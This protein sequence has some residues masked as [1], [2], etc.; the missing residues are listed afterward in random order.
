MSRTSASVLQPGR[1][2]LCTL[3]DVN[4]RPDGMTP[5]QL[6]EGLR[7]LSARVYSA[8][9]VRARRR[10]F[11]AQRSRAVRERSAPALHLRRA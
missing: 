5:E 9:G 8:E 1:W 10:R 7:W 11:F 3:F 4:H 2:D 6:R